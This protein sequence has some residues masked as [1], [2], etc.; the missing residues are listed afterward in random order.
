[1]QGLALEGPAPA[2][3]HGSAPTLAH[4]RPAHTGAEAGHRRQYEG[5]RL[6]LAAEADQQLPLPQVA[7]CLRQATQRRGSEAE[8]VVLSSPAQGWRAP[9]QR[10]SGWLFL[11]RHSLYL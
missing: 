6:E 2:G 5:M 9:R 8:R 4:L 1:M 10:C 11:L 7:L 3:A